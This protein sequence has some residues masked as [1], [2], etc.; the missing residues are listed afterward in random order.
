[1]TTRCSC[2]KAARSSSVKAIWSR[3]LMLAARGSARDQL[4]AG[5]GLGGGAYGAAGIL[6]LEHDGVPRLLERLAHQPVDA[7]EAE[8]DDHGAVLKLIDDMALLA[9]PSG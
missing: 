9:R 6:G 7:G 3:R 5:D 2:R 1:M 8:L 4:V